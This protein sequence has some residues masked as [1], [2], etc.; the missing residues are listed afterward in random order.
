MSV[1]E[2]GARK[3]WQ[4]QRL[5]PL[6]HDPTSVVDRPPL[7][8]QLRQLDEKETGE[9]SGEGERKKYC[10]SGISEKNMS[11]TDSVDPAAIGDFARWLMAATA[12]EDAAARCTA[13]CRSCRRVE[14]YWQSIPLTEHRRHAGWRRSQRR[15]ALIQALQAFWRVAR[16]IP[17]WSVI[18]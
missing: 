2:L 15:L 6:G 16:V 7:L 8:P 17:F 12:A 13:V 1:Q 3:N 14:A 10:S 18:V 11:E 5:R 4:K 9:G